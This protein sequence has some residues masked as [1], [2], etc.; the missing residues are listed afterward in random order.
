MWDYDSVIGGNKSS[1]IEKFEIKNNYKKI[2]SSN[3]NVALCGA[4]IKVNKDSGL[5]SF[6]EQIIVGKVLD[7]KIP[8]EEPFK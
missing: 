4:I 1:W 5:S 2:Y 6:A 8:K 3:Q 7:N